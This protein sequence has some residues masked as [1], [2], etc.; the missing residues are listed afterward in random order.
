MT[1]YREFQFYNPDSSSKKQSHSISSETSARGFQFVFEST[2]P[3]PLPEPP[4]AC[5]DQD[6]VFV[7][8]FEY[9]G[10]AKPVDL[11]STFDR[12]TGRLQPCYERW[13]TSRDTISPLV[14]RKTDSKKYTVDPNAA[15]RVGEQF[16]ECP[17]VDC[18]FISASTKPSTLARHFD[19]V[20]PVDPCPICHDP[21]FSVMDIK[22]RDEHLM[23]THPGIRVMPLRAAAKGRCQRAMKE[24]QRESALDADSRSPTSDLTSIF[25]D[26]PALKTK[27]TAHGPG[28]YALASKRAHGPAIDRFASQSQEPNV[29]HVDEIAYSFCDRCGRDHR[30]LDDSADRNHHDLTCRP[31]VPDDRVWCATCG[32]LDLPDAETASLLGAIFPHQCA[33][34]DEAVVTCALCGFCQDS[35]KN[36]NVALHA[37]E[38]RGYSGTLGRY[39]PYCCCEFSSGWSL[40]TRCGHITICGDRPT[41]KPA[42]TPFD[43]YPELIP[44]RKRRGRADEDEDEAE[45][46]NM[47]IGKGTSKRA[48]TGNHVKKPSSSQK[49]A[50]GDNTYLE[51]NNK[52]MNK[53]VQDNEASGETAVT[54][55]VCQ[56]PV[57]NRTG[58]L[59]TPRNTASPTRRQPTRATKSQQGHGSDA[60]TIPSSISKRRARAKETSAARYASPLPEPDSQT[61]AFAFKGLRTS[62]TTDSNWRAESPTWAEDDRDFFVTKTMYCSRCLRC[63]PLK[64][65][66]KNEP[67]A[68]DQLAAHEDPRSGCGIPHR[69]GDPD[70][71]GVGLPNHSG[72]IDFSK[73]YGGKKLMITA[74]RAQF[75]RDY[76]LYT[77]TMFP[78]DGSNNRQAV[79]DNDPN[80]EKWKNNWLLPWPPYKGD[81]PIPHSTAKC[82]NGRVDAE[83]LSEDEDDVNSAVGDAEDDAECEDGGA[84]SGSEADE[85]MSVASSVGAGEDNTEADGEAGSP[86]STRPRRAIAAEQKAKTRSIRHRKI[87]DATYR[88]T[89]DSDEEEEDVER[90]V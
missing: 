11:S 75:L 35:G 55:Y 17:Y 31:G 19:E 76:P 66:R 79:W 74:V 16:T 69:L 78:A 49:D 52:D 68:A 1:I 25:D 8:A 46:E 23:E 90:R 20:H 39:C 45:D 81:G 5:I 89:A 82:D 18:G 54:K 26:E 15:S 33:D 58:P 27:P 43:L 32:E 71:D 36:E 56:T 50:V 60:E 48:R 63:A 64:I 62:K 59:P 80:N 73:R 87:K 30:I 65:T 53:V 51:E 61:T 57:T 4:G 21:K 22:Q 77:H 88:P 72:W 29:A 3:D 67:C 28:R 24:Q 85:N 13:R 44:S 38:C 86:G 40:Q 42:L 34:A 83:D 47:S 9:T 7:P 84:A 12:N 6:E 2:T 10:A 70:V 14:R 41:V 37:R